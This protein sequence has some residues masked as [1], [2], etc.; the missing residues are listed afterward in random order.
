[1]KR[2]TISIL[3]YETFLIINLLFT[4]KALLCWTLNIKMLANVRDR[5]L[6]FV[7]P[8]LCGFQLYILKHRFNFHSTVDLKFIPA[9]HSIQFN[10]IYCMCEN[11]ILNQ[12]HIA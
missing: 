11:V 10:S 6:H 3:Q 5:I 8:L 9:Y 1:M 4:L 2:Y 7:G 12:I